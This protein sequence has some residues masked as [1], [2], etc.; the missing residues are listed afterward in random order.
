LRSPENPDL[1]VGRKARWW[2]LGL[3][4]ATAWVVHGATLGNYLYTHDGWNDVLLGETVLT[5]SLPWTE[6]LLRILPTLSYGLRAAF[7]LNMAVWHAPNLL[8]HGINAALVV[9]LALRLGMASWPAR[10]AGV[11]F[12]SAPLL[13]HPVEW[14]GG[15][16]DLF[17]TAGALGAVVAF[18]DRRIALAC[19]ATLFAVLSKESG[20][21]A[22]LV[23]TVVAVAVSFP[24]DL[25]AIKTLGRRL[26]PLFIVAGVCGGIR[27]AQVRSAPHDAMAGR[28]V[29]A[30]PVGFMTAAPGAVGVAAVAPAVALLELRDPANVAP[31]G[32]GALVL[33][34]LL[35]WWRRARLAAWLALA[36][37][38]ALLPVS[39]IAMD[40]PQMVDNS[41]YLYLTVALC[42]PI[43]PLLIGA[44][45]TVERVALAALVVIGLW[46]GADRVADSLEQTEAVEVVAEAVLQAPE[47]SR[48]WVLTNLYDEATARFL[49]SRY[50]TIH[51]KIQA[52]YVMRGTWRAYARHPGA[53]DDAAQAY[54]SPLPQP[55]EPAMVA[56]TDRLLE[57]RAD[58]RTVAAVTLS[59]RPAGQWSDVDGRW[60]A[61]KPPDPADD[62]ITVKDGRVLEMPFHLGPIASA[63]YAPLATLPIPAG[64]LTGVELH[65]RVQSDARLRYGSGYHERFG[66]LFWGDTFVSF[67]L[68]TGGELQIVTLDLSFDP[69]ALSFDSATADALGLLPLNYPGEVTVERVRVRR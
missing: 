38:V 24:R 1:T 40:L 65:L 19:A 5:G 49:M 12:A 23:V 53:G 57:Q 39:L 31:V 16:Y 28:A 48:V 64:P 52:I 56:A 25:G 36:G 44:A 13:A 14:I 10:A 62:P 37:A 8:F 47:G 7:G 46:G 35:G 27:V 51:R 18:L 54:F 43:L 15:G 2:E 32:F 45:H 4:A 55:F 9:A 11:L 60:T 3:A 29:Q 63:D 34:G 41:R 30:D 20:M 69:A 26:L 22:P 6:N 68:E 66:I 17:A 67:E 33:L 61:V 50:L 58:S 42:A 59:G 21:A